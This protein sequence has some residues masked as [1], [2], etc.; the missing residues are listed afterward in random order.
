MGLGAMGM[1]A[2]IRRACAA[3][4]TLLALAAP[5]AA[6]NLPTLSGRVVDAAQVLDPGVRA[7]LVAKLRAFEARTSHQLA[8][9]TVSSL[10]GRSVEDYANRLFRVWALGGKDK[11]D[12]VLLLV[13]PTE[14]KLRIEVGYG[15]EGVLTDALAK[16]IIDDFM[17][18]QLRA[19]KVGAAVTV[20]A[21]QIID[22]VAGSGA[23]VRQILEARAAATQVD[24][25]PWWRDVRWELLLP[26]VFVT[27]FIF[28][29]VFFPKHADPVPASG[30]RDWDRDNLFRSS[31]SS[32]SSS[33]SDL[34]SDSFSGGG[35]S[36]GGGGASGSW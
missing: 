9:A 36:S 17:L 30:P 18:P 33:S 4:L 29:R 32:F 7:D 14:R 21:E 5:A 8:I 27:L 35:G 22:V 24:N 2:T 3:A 1:V 19:G 12:G 34:S 6:Q 11:N 25:R 13:A 23:Q 10:Q 16:V 20:G 26:L 28:L 15:L 31:S